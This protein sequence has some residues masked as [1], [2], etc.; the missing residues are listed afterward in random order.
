MAIKYSSVTGGLFGRKASAWTGLSQSPG[1]AQMV[2]AREDGAWWKAWKVWRKV[3]GTWV[4]VLSTSKLA[5]DAAPSSVSVSHVDK[6]LLRN[7]VKA[8]FTVATGMPLPEAAYEL[9]L[10][11]VNITTPAES[12]VVVLASGGTHISPA[13]VG[14]GNDDDEVYIRLY[15]RE[16]GEAFPFEGPTAQTDN[17]IIT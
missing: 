9:V 4:Q 12:A 11:Y 15:Y 6:P 2:H 10:D 13:L 7:D 5:P 17:Y 1:G 16:A 14:G 8:N 3:G